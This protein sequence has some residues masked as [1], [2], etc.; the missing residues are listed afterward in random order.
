MR[1]A[2]RWFIAVLLLAIIAGCFRLH[3]GVQILDLLPGRLK[4]VEGLKLYQD[5][6]SNN[7]EL[8][9]SL[10]MADAASASAAAE[11]LASA[12]RAQSN[13]VKTVRW[14]AAWMEEP[15]QSAELLAYMWFNQSPAD[16]QALADRLTVTNL[17]NVIEST[18]ETLATSFSPAD[19]AR[20]AYDPYGLTSLPETT[21]A[22]VPQSLRDQNWFASADGTYHVLFV[23]ARPA[24]ASYSESIAWVDSIHRVVNDWHGSNPNFS[25]A[26]L[27]FTG[28]PAFAAEI[29]AGMRHDLTSSVLGTL[30]FIGLL[31]WIAYRNWRPLIL[32]IVLLILIV[33]V[34][35]ALGG[36]ALG[37]LN[38]VSLGFGGI[39]LGITA[40]YALVLYQSSLANRDNDPAAARRKVAGG[41]LWSAATTA[42]AFLLLWISGF[43]GLAQLG[44]LAAL[45][46][47]FGAILILTFFPMAFKFSESHRKIPR[48]PAFTR[49]R[50]FVV[51]STVFVIVFVIVGWAWRRPVID[52]TADAMQ[53]VNSQ[54]YAALKEMERELGQIE[55]PYIAV[56]RGKTVDDVLRR[57]TVLN[58]SLTNAVGHKEI[59]SFMLPVLLW[60]RTDAQSANRRTA[61]QL[62][63][64]RSA[65]HEAALTNGFS[66]NALVLTDALLKSWH[67]AAQSPGVFWP[68]NDMSSWI[69][70]RAVARKTNE[71]L[72]MG[73]V[74]PNKGE[75]AS[76]AAGLERLIPSDETWLAG[77]QPLAGELLRMIGRKLIWMLGG[78]LVLLVLALRLALGRWIEVGLGFCALGLSALWLCAFMQMMGWSWNLFNVM[79]LP[80]LLGAGVD[81]T[82]LMQLALRRHHGDLAAAHREIGVALVLSC[83]TAAVGFGS[84]SWA[85]N[86]GLA[87]LGRVSAVGILATGFVAIFLLPFW[88]PRN[89]YAEDAPS[90]P[91]KIYSAVSWNFGLKIARFVP[92]RLLYA[93]AEFLSVCYCWTH[94]DRREVVVENLLPVLNDRAEAEKACAQLFR[95]FGRKLVDLWRCE[96]G[97]PAAPL[98]TEFVGADAL[99]DAH[100]RKQGVLLVTPHLGNWEVGGYALAARG[101]K[102]HVVTLS[103]PAAGLTETRAQARARN[104]IETIVVG[105]D[106]FGFVPIIKLLQDGA[107]M[108]ILPDRPLESSRVTV[109]F[110]DKPFH[111][112]IAI[113]D[114]AR[115]SGCLIVPVF[116]PHTGEGYRIE[117]LPPIAYERD[118]LGSRDARQQLT[119]RIFRAFEP[120]VRQYAAQWYH[121]IPIWPLAKTYEKTIILDTAGVDSVGRGSRAR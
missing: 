85:S 19:L 67:E 86:E 70:Q 87:G 59:S 107:V 23:Q 28:P 94:E 35:L 84:L 8:I 33:G 49:T 116:L 10:R 27:A 2:R 69:L 72:A 11:S 14:Q 61:E 22:Q 20:L 66:S 57:L 74:Y 73:P 42:G 21:M 95:N 47:I 29:A 1:T 90:G 108:A 83:A 44:T 118:E 81:Y 31:F 24:L 88:G 56:V 60:P 102:L 78:I 92:R 76:A 101:I 25:Q 112:A 34:A 64:E 50:G 113:A 82:I 45:G 99:L 5:N 96:A 117:L 79:A 3:F 54:P 52:Y 80:L 36:L 110:F 103:E 115:A 119:Q 37:T 89:K 58:T 105:D 18:K 68:T 38:V 32:I 40:D 111:A 53:P 91:P 114:L 65:L 121:F 9:V 63:Q 6:F 30:V 4:V 98:I 41:I 62:W 26:R 109:D 75:S 39:L 17:P 13:L 51:A 15:T 97:L 16:F 12:L 104:G 106:P 48:L 120:F 71:F 100:R 46:L 55:E 43:P 93:A 77:W 7:R